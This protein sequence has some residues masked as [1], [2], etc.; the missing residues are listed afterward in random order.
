[1]NKHR[2]LREVARQLE[3]IYRSRKSGV[4]PGLQAKSRCEG[5]MQAGEYMRLVTQEELSE[6]IERVHEE[7]L[8]ESIEDRRKRLKKQQTWSSET[9]DYS[10]FETPTYERGRHR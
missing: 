4:E 2:Y 6:T 1:M 10:E 8:G 9:I 3:A 5:F 7:V